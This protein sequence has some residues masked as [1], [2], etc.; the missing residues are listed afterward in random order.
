MWSRTEQSSRST[1]FGTVRRVREG[2]EIILSAPH[3]PSLATLML[4]RLR[5]AAWHG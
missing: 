1:P 4:V 5:G 3:L 2:D